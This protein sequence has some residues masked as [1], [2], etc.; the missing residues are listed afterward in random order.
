[1][2]HKSH[3]WDPLKKVDPAGNIW[4][5][6]LLFVWDLNRFSDWCSTE[7]PDLSGKKIEI[8]SDI[9]LWRLWKVKRMKTTTNYFCSTTLKIQTI[10]LLFARKVVV[11]STVPIYAHAPYKL[12]HLEP[13]QVHS[14]ERKV[15]QHCGRKII[16]GPNIRNAIVKDFLS[17]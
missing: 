2:L 11:D 9:K 1:M 10:S 14:G 8:K 5:K 4:K 16:F 3:V 15:F 7:T 17:E 6:A 13:H 12:E